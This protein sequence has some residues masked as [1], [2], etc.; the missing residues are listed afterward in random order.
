MMMWSSLPSKFQPRPCVPPANAPV[1]LMSEAIPDAVPS[2]LNDVL[3]IA[4]GAPPDESSSRWRT[5][6]KLS[7]PFSSQVSCFPYDAPS[8]G[9]LLPVAL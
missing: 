8:A 9:W 1:A 2:L 7:A 3:S 4:C 5:I 6:L